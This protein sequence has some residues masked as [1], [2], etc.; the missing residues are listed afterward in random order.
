MVGSIQRG[1]AGQRDDSHPGRDRAVEDFVI[2][3]SVQFKTYDWFIPE[4]FN[5]IFLD[6]VC[7]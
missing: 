2:A 7:E 4:I 5:L 6:S 3:L 1:H